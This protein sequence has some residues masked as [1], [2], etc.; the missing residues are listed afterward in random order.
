MMMWQPRKVH[1]K[2]V[3]LV[4]MNGIKLARACIMRRREHRVQSETTWRPLHA[5]YHTCQ[6]NLDVVTIVETS[7]SQISPRNRALLKAFS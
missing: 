7:R 5:A 1:W 2:K 4:L 3:R 6:A